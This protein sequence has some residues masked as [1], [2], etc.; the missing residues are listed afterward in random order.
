[1]D[2]KWIETELG[3]LAHTSVIPPANLDKRA[4]N[5][6]RDAS[7]KAG[8]GKRMSKMKALAVIPASVLIVALVFFTTMALLQLTGP[9]GG[10]R[11][12]LGKYVSEDGLA[13]VE[14]KEGNQFVF[15]RH[16][17]TSYSPNG[18][19][20][21]QDHEL[22][23]FVADAEQYRF[24]IVGDTIV[25][26]GGGFAESLIAKGTV[27]F[28]T[29]EQGYREL[30][31]LPDPYP[32]ELA[33]EN[34]DVVYGHNIGY[35]IKKLDRFLDNAKDNRSDW[36]R[37]TQYTVE[38]DAIIQDLKHNQ[39]KLTLF[40]D[41]TR[42]KFGARAITEYDLSDVYKETRDDAVYYLV[43]AASGEELI[44]MTYAGSRDYQSF[45]NLKV[46]DTNT[47]KTNKGYQFSVLTNGEF[48]SVILI[49]VPSSSGEIKA[50]YVLSG[51][52]TTGDQFLT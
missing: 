41:T 46:V 26:Q 42:D 30:E 35:N 12:A 39:G 24:S 7:R 10:G 22:V 40:I 4:R 48:D 18:E 44:L 49:Y 37:I 13:W 34:G 45:D 36:V 17:A 3:R 11:L 50:A 15:I 1:M 31:Q 52:R 20:F 2:E 8:R 5:L 29:G 23:L 25:F 16:I 43:K 47:A 9:S 21:I 32:M 6:I 28:L 14:L 51:D 19:F 27:F 38:G 33:K